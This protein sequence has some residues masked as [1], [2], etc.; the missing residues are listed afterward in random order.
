MTRHTFLHRARVFP[1]RLCV[2]VAALYSYPAQ[3]FAPAGNLF[4]CLC[5][6][7]AGAE[8]CAVARVH[9]ARISSQT[10]P[11]LVEP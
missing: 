3:R 7:L 6:R 10:V 9:F 2:N 8:D 1:A 5:S 11:W 4:G